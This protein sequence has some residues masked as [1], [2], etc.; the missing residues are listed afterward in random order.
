MCVIPCPR[1]TCLSLFQIFP[2]PWQGRAPSIQVHGASK[3]KRLYLTED[4]RV[5]PFGLPCRGS[6]SLVPRKVGKMFQPQIQSLT[7][8][9]SSQVFPLPI[10]STDSPTVLKIQGGVIGISKCGVIGF[11]QLVAT[12]RSLLCL[13]KLAATVLE[14]TQH[15]D[16]SGCSFTILFQAT[17]LRWLQSEPLPPPPEPSVSSCEWNFAH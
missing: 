11:P 13:G 5:L 15:R 17:N 10:Y 8:T 16:F 2:W 6:T 14:D 7:S 4:K 9:E 3:A 12:L 1:A